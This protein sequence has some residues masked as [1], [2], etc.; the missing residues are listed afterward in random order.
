MNLVK[1]SIFI[2]VITCVVAAIAINLV[3]EG[4]QLPIHWNAS[5]EVD[6]MTNA[7]TALIMPPVLMIASLLVLT[8]LKHLEPRKENLTHSL[9]AARAIIAS[10]VALLAIIEAGYLAMLLGV[11]FEM[12]KVI[13]ASVGL[14]LMV[15]GN[16]MSK[17]RSNFFIGIRTPWTLSSDEV[18][19]KTHRLG[20]KLFMLAGVITML[21]APFANNE[22]LKLVIPVVVVPAALIP[23]GYSWWLWREEQKKHP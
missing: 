6:R 2:T 13:L 5:G 15:A 10:V 18:W 8:V 11:E 21:V 16:Y 23:V 14:V 22:L 17:T 7:T 12:H 9:T 4:L 1:F 3:P 19:R 20:G